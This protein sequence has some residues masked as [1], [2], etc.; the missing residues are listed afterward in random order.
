MQLIQD[1]KLSHDLQI[2][3]A[4]IAALSITFDI[5]LFTYNIKDFKFIPELNLYKN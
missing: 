4:I 3:D 1:Y 5:P 2:P